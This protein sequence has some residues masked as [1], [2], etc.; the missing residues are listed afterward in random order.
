MQRTF[1]KRSKIPASAQAVFDWHEAPGAFKKLTPPWA[2]VRV[3]Y[4]EG[5]I[6][7]GAEV[8][9]LVGRLPF[10]IR[11]DLEHVDYRYGESFTDQQVRGPFK[12]WRH[13]HRMIPDGD[14]QCV[15]EDEVTFA[16]P[17]CPFLSRWGL[18]IIEKKL[19]KL[20]VFRHDVTRRAFE[21]NG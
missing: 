21:G 18:R 20:F 15:L 5:G 2:P 9:L 3:L 7:D 11:W 13:V 16:L 19:D 6:K 4:H 1:I 12:M 14:Q 8:S 17:R 10:A